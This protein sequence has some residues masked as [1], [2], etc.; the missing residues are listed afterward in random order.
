MRVV[1]G[2]RREYVDVLYSPFT[3]KSRTAGGGGGIGT[4]ISSR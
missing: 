1:V 4:G 2:A 3:R